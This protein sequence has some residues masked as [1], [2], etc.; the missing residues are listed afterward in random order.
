MSCSK[1]VGGGRV[2]G[3]R[4]IT[5][6]I[7]LSVLPS[8]IP[9]PPPPLP[10]SLEVIYKDDMSGNIHQRCCATCEQHSAERHRRRGEG[11][12]GGGQWGEGAENKRD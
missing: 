11:L 4:R 1:R 7:L 6:I 12:G 10:P 2:V 9:S 3:G 8:A 5:Y